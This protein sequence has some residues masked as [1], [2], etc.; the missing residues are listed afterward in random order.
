[1]RFSAI[2]FVSYSEAI[3][4]D[5]S[6]SYD[7]YSDGSSRYEPSFSYDPS[8]YDPSSLCGGPSASSGL[9]ESVSAPG[10]KCVALV[11]L[12]ISLESER[13][14]LHV[15]GDIA[16]VDAGFLHICPVW[17]LPCGP[18]RSYPFDARLSLFA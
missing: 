16:S 11:T 14:S 2:A 12:G 9:P 8:S 4:F 6:H 3:V 5:D 15:W 17:L 13:R 7:S 18:M 10:K 1:M